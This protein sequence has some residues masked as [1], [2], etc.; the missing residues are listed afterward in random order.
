KCSIYTSHI[1]VDS[2]TPV[3]KESA[4]ETNESNEKKEDKPADK[5]TQKLIAD[6]KRCRIQMQNTR[7]SIEKPPVKPFSPDIFNSLSPYYNIYTVN[8][9]LKDLENKDENPMRQPWGHRATAL[10][11]LDPQI[12]WRMDKYV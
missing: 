7:K 9:L 1:P 6:L 12:A 4:E 5:K 3:E 10:G 11:V 2:E 8:Y